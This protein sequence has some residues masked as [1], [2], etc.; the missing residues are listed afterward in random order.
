[1]NTYRN[2]F[3][4]TLAQSFVVCFSVLLFANAG[5]AHENHNKMPVSIKKALDIGLSTAHQY[6]R[7]DSPFALKKLPVSWAALDQSAVKIHKNG[8][9]YYIVSVE[10]KA[11]AKTLYVLIALAGDVFDA[12][13]SGEFK[14][15]PKPGYI[16][17]D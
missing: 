10:N 7:E 5:Y 6:S 16:P 11:E 13:F 2:S 3:L 14:L 1:M 17:H 12:N 4:F 15:F 8:R 9:G